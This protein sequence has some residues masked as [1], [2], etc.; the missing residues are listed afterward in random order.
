MI[1]KE[2]A[3]SIVSWMNPKKFVKLWWNLLQWHFKAME[4]STGQVT[5]DY[6][7]NICNLKSKSVTGMFMRPIM[8]IIENIADFKL[9]CPFKKGT[10]LRTK[11][12]NFSVPIISTLSKPNVQKL[13]TLTIY[14]GRQSIPVFA[15]EFPYM[16]IEI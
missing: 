9:E 1:M 3:R 2:E 13:F 11:P 7:L 14:A 5:F 8:A 12:F 10:W 15:I 16:K 4:V 6:R